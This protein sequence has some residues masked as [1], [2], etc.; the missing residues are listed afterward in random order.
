MGLSE[1]KLEFLFRMK[2]RLSGGLGN[3]A[4]GFKKTGDAANK[5]EQR[6]EK[7]S[8][9]MSRMQTVGR[10]LVATLTA[11]GG[12]FAVFSAVSS[13]ASFGDSMS[14]VAAVTQATGEE[15]TLLRDL[16]IEMGNTTRFS[17]SEAASGLEELGRA[18]LTTFEA[19]EALPSTLSL[20]AAG[21]LDLGQ[22]SDI[23]TN[24]MSAF[25]LQADEVG[26]VA[27]VLAFTAANS[28]TDVRQLGEAF[29]YAGGTAGLFGVSM[30]EVAAS[31]GV[32]ANQ[33]RK[34]SVAGSGI[35]TMFTLLAT[36][37][38]K[39]DDILA[40]V[41]TNSKDL[42]G[43]LESSETGLIDVLEVMSQLEKT[44][45][46]KLF[47]S[48]GGPT[49]NALIQNLD[50]LK[51][52]YTSLQNAE[53]AAERIAFTMDNNLGGSLRRA[54]AAWQGFILSFGQ[55][56]QG[57]LR[58]FVEYMALVVRY[59]T[60]GQSGMD[61]IKETIEALG[62]NVERTAKSIEV[63]ATVLKVL[64]VAL[65]AI[66]GFAVAVI[67]LKAFA[68]ALLVV[69]GPI[70]I[71]V[72]GLGLMA[73]LLY[74]YRD[75]Q[76]ETSA[77]TTTWG[78]IASSTFDRVKHHGSN[79]FAALK[80]RFSTFKE[81]LSTGGS[82]VFEFADNVGTFI[83]K[84]LNLVIG[85][86]VTTGV[87]IKVQ[88]TSI[89]KAAGV[90]GGELSEILT[91]PIAALGKAVKGDFAGAKEEF[92][93]A[94]IS[95]TDIGTELI[96]IMG[97]GYAEIASTVGRDYVGIAQGR[98]KGVISPALD[99]INS[100]VE[101]VQQGA[102]EK[103][104][105]QLSELTD[106]SVAMLERSKGTVLDATANLEFAQTTGDDN[107][108]SIAENNLI[109]A[110][111]GMEKV[112]EM[113]EQASVLSS[114]NNLT[115]LRDVLDNIT[116]MV[117][118]NEGL[119]KAF[120][121]QSDLSALSIPEGEVLPDA[122]DSSAAD[123]IQ[124]F[125]E[126]VA[127][128]VE[129]LKS[130]AAALGQSAQ[131]Q[132]LLSTAGSLGIDILARETQARAAL[133]S[134][135]R[136]LSSLTE[137]QISNMGLEAQAERELQALRQ[138][139]SASN[140]LSIAQQKE[141]VRLLGL[142]IEKLQELSGVSL[143]ATEQNAVA[144]AVIEAQNAA[145]RAGL[146]LTT[147]EIGLIQQKAE[148]EYQAA[149]RQGTAL[150]LLSGKYANISAV[151]NEFQVSLAQGIGGAFNTLGDAAAGFFTGQ[152]TNWAQMT[153]TILRS[154]ATM[155]VK[156][157]ILLAVFSLMNSIVPGSGTAAAN[158]MGSSGQF[159]ADGAA[160]DKGSR[161]VNSPTAFKFRSGTQETT[162]IMGEAG[163]EGILPLARTSS[164][165]LGVH[166]TGGSMGGGGG[167]TTNIFSPSVT[168]QVATTG[169]Q[170][171]DQANISKGSEMLE[172][173]MDKKMSEFYL[174]QQRNQGRLGNI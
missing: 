14:A 97:E 39:I 47:G 91:A 101:I 129:G 161:V 166:T 149:T 75:A 170:E 96:S 94:A 52:F 152:E 139:A 46:T 95:P 112:R 43:T 13:I 128:S 77:G 30:E 37:G 173:V 162:G 15:F 164:G 89:L 2:D 3:V 83:A 27:D 124:R 109:A 78:N 134:Q 40:K 100:E 114:E 87:A 127:Q 67:T 106:K 90:F 76:V 50:Q 150:D 137:Q 104:G 171:T 66:A 113:V 55:D 144:N 73:G 169:D 154:I 86:L 125:N 17:A 156:F 6:M 145:K 31:L 49:A 59:I 157:L 68:A 82:K 18:G 165:K 122:G 119:T 131:Q 32:L 54:A 72:G 160:F 19:M 110:Q 158:L 26:R 111:R 121:G 123:A 29:V 135:Y 115:G 105:N 85:M 12:G 62:W 98:L 9:R 10:S 168:M 5:S 56:Q 4:K 147:E 38:K 25:N 7:A 71:V 107:L 8:R 148:L 172:A 132:T 11:I 174:K 58:N 146:D 130:Q 23:T 99:F 61:K 1:R 92:L 34:A 116:E 133:G 142:D 103:F 143:A 93:Q 120:S 21:M 126:R 63:M 108:I 136:D 102:V 24:I 20:A 153:G 155:I 69:S 79:A 65:G 141:R 167:S 28:N 42:I 117:L 159:F 51:L 74:N 163:A 44:D 35:N 48:R 57:G 151:S 80:T 84:A 33:G 53:G 41:N 36:G 60:D 70:G 138:V 45:V 22:A 81:D 118:K 140:D 16:A 64:G 88:F